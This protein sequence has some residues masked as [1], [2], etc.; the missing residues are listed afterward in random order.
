MNISS[1]INSLSEE[2]I[3]SAA[4]FIGAGLIYILRKFSF[5]N[6]RISEFELADTMGKESLQRDLL[7]MNELEDDTRVYYVIKF[8][9]QNKKKV[10]MRQLIHLSILIIQM[11]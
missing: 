9:Y 8:D 10:L 2:T 6:Q 7:I 3:I 11:F 5:L 1:M 4:V